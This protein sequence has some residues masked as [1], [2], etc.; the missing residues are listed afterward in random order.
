VTPVWSAAV[1]PR[2]LRVR[3]FGCETDHPA[4]FDGR[5]HRLRVAVDNDGIERI[6]VGGS[7]EPLRIDVVSGTI[8]R[9][10]VCLEPAI[11]LARSLPPQVAALHRLD[12]LLRQVVWNRPVDRALLRL[13]VALRSADA[14]RHGASLRDIARIILGLPDWPGD[15]EFAKSSARRLVALGGLLMQASPATIVQ[16]KV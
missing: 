7:G 6:C 12:C 15:G 4:A 9:G 11:D 1:D 3:C 8:Q 14:R 10:I 2:V 13:F 5:T 16:K